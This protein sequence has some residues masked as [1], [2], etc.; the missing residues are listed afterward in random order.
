MVLGSELH[1]VWGYIGIT[2]YRGV[3]GLSYRAYIITFY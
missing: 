1:Y 3:F 2:G